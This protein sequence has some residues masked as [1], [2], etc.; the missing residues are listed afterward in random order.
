MKAAQAATDKVIE[1]EQAATAAIE[2]Q[3]AVMTGSIGSITSASRAWERLLAT[4]DPAA[5]S[6]QAMERALLT[7][8][9]AARK[10]GV[11][12]AEVERVLGMV[13]LQHDAVARA[14]AAQAQSYRDLAVAGREAA[15][16]DH[17]QSSINRTL[18]IGVA[19]VNSARASAAV[20]EA[21]GREADQM[22]AKVAVLRAEIDPLSTAQMH[23]N[24]ELEEYA[25]LAAR[26]AISTEELA[27]AQ[28][29][30]RGRF[31]VTAASVARGSKLMSYEMRNLQFQMIDIAQSIPLAFQSPLYFLQNMGFQLAQIGQIF[32]GRG[33]LRAGI[34][35]MGTMLGGITSRFAS[36][37]AGS[38]ALRLLGTAATAAAL[39]FGAIR[40]QASEAE[41][42]VVGIGETFTAVFQVI[43]DAIHNSVLGT[44][45]DAVT[46]GF[47][48]AFQ[49]LGSAAVDIAELIIN[50]FHAA[51]YDI[52]AYWKSFPDQLGAIFIGAANAAITSLNYL[53]KKSSDAADEII[54]AL[55]RVTGSDIPLLN[56]PDQSIAP[57]DNQYLENL[58]KA[59]ADRNAAIEQIMQS[60]P[61]RDFAS[62]VVDKIA[63]NHALEGLDAL[64]N[65]S[66]DSAAG[67]ANGF[68]SAIGGI[69]QAANGVKIEFGGMSQQ[70][71]N[72]SRAFEDAK[73]AQLGQI[74]GAT[75]ELHKAQNEA[76]E[77]E[78]TLAAA[79]QAKIADVF[80][81]GFA[82]D[83]N[84]AT[85]AVER[86]VNAI[87]R[88]FAAY[89]TGNAGSVRDFQ[90]SLDML[91]QTLL[92]QGGDPV[93]INAFFDSIVSGEI[94]V[95]QLNSTVNT[96]HT[97]IAN[98]PNKTVTITVVTRQVGSGTQS[99]YSVPSATGGGSSTVGVTRY[100]AIPGT[101]S[102]PSMTATTVPNTSGY[103]SMGGTGDLGTST[104]GVTRFRS[105]N[106]ITV[107]PV[108]NDATQSW[109]YPARAAGGPVSA[110]T[111]Y[112][113]GEHGPELVM[114]QSAATVVPHDQSLALAQS[115]F[116][117]REATREQDRIWTVL[118]NIEANTRKT[119]GALDDMKTASAA[120]S[121]GSSSSYS[122]GSSSSSGGAADDPLAA[123]YV[124][125]L[126][127]ARSNFHAAGIVGA[128]SIGYGAQGLA[129]TPEQV[130]HRAV[131]GMDT[132]G[133]I[134]PG[135]TQKVE[136]FKNPNERVIVARPD[137]FEDQR[138]GS[139]SSSG[140]ERPIVIHFS[141][142]VRSDGAAPSR[143]SLAEQRRASA[144]GLQDALGSVLGR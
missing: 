104:V 21:A 84:A 100:G 60:T 122:G 88:L 110:N 30:A 26:G 46:S 106:T 91:R 134:A 47:S 5:R 142:T 129:A 34:S 19:D 124:K 63:T 132:G 66:F 3:G 89:D 115:G 74:Q 97:S 10:L 76:A 139:S 111:P 75:T 33:G 54:A 58:K 120:I 36:F 137:Q 86:N 32:M 17:A 25:V 82:G 90:N 105:S 113:V 95:R 107:Q 71:I 112:W 69:G 4:V 133:M 49:K 55:N 39:G 18:G 38:T 138:S 125:A 1:R 109:G 40:D 80:G 77:L 70:A 94:K 45:I 68:S 59:V 8:D 61:L 103:G 116:T 64:K 96:L 79:S 108:W 102:G 99:Q 44:G 2:R 23:L 48:Y 53:V 31:D 92:A 73:L 37:L 35:E 121:S 83:A 65:I 50:A 29:L 81:K 117:G 56:A 16:A 15:A 144:L 123:A 52:V 87:H 141:Q 85:E 114:P 131:Y 6:T 119:Y 51:F 28:A 135:D 14:A 101:Q 93:A 128:G 143:E 42:R 57:L 24:T 22:A 41:H 118:M 98:L 20:F 27:A 13:R 7:A 130:A 72:V 127:T 136:F 11:S 67:S 140:G 126:Q 62:D 9:T 43:G 78:K 12:E